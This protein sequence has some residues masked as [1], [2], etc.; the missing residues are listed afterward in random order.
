MSENSINPLLWISGGPGKGKTIMSIF[1]T[2]ELEKATPGN[3]IYSFCSAQ[4]ERRNS[5]VNVLRSLVHQ[6]LARVPSLF[7]H[8]KPYFESPERQQ[9]TL[10]S[11]QVLWLIFWKMASDTNLPRMY[12]VLDGLD[13]CD[14]AGLHF[15]ITK[16]AE[17]FSPKALPP[18]RN[19]LKLVIVSRPIR[20]IGD[21]RECEQINLDDDNGEAVENDIQKFIHARVGEF[22]GLQGFG[23]ELQ[24]YVQKTLLER[25]EGT[26]LWAGLTLME[27]SRQTTCTQLLKA[28]DKIPLG[29]SAVYS[30]IILRIPEQHRENSWKILQW[31]V[32]A[33]HPLSLA[34][35][36][37]ATGLVASQPG[38]H[39]GQR[40][41]DGVILCGPILKLEDST[42]NLVHASAR[43]YFLREMADSHPVL[44]RAR[45]KQEEAHLE[46][47]RVCVECISNSGLQVAPCSDLSSESN[48]LV[49][50]AIRSLL[51]HLVRSGQ[52]A[53]KLYHSHKS[54]FLEDSTVRDNWW[55]TMMFMSPK[56]DKDTRATPILH[57]A[58]R[59]SET[60]V[61]AIISQETRQSKNKKR[62]DERDKDGNTA[63]FTALMAGRTDFF[64]LLLRGGVNIEAKSKSGDTLLTYCVRFAE[65]HVA[66]VLENGANVETLVT[67][68]WG[69]K[70]NALHIAASSGDKGVVRLLLERGADIHARTD[71]GATALMH[72]A[73]MGQESVAQLLLDKGVNLHA[74]DSTG[75]TALMAAAL[76]G[77]NSMVRFLLEHGAHINTT[78]KKGWTAL[79][80]A[81]LGGRESTVRL[82]LEQGALV[83]RERNR[84]TCA[85]LFIYDGCYGSDALCL[86]ARWGHVEIVKLLLENGANPRSRK[87]EGTA[88][89]L[90]LKG[91]HDAVVHLLDE[92]LSRKRRW[93]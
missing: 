68:P 88:R 19:G 23:K 62:V 53:H 79:G 58:S 12:C 33:R 80:M 69:E 6:L 76:L 3:V 30:Q 39:E 61:Q 89:H 16:L 48:P 41:R 27:L 77:R 71:N 46:M 32:L 37:T 60:W 50:Y 74:R 4:D 81:A 10:S 25:A 72:A 13:E 91:E 14:E 2:E 63:L 26:F 18:N 35:L 64:P 36:A 8:T 84:L 11:L 40:I 20:I 87:S 24:E 82:L 75:L 54:F 29:L 86:A 47:A 73:Y 9:Q 38:M 34:Q 59:C 45:I 21:M 31:V 92:A 5:V 1:L 93:I 66:A 51:Y 44:E 15:L 57:M 56:T 7:K 55:T 78:S 22:S 49:E 90:A 85:A 65:H 70:R 67:S 43:D 83:N 28:L 17:V 52:Q 42:V